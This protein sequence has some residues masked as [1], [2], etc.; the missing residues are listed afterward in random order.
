M[1]TYAAVIITFLEFQQQYPKECAV[2]TRS[3]TDYDTT[4][5]DP[6]HLVITLYTQREES[7]FLPKCIIEVQLMDP[8]SG[9]MPDY[10]LPGDPAPRIFQGEDSN[11]MATVN[12]IIDYLR[13]VRR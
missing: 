6:K 10:I 4:P 9:V 7:P 11:D 13:Y 12:L 2:Y 3:W 5:P 1:T 8:G